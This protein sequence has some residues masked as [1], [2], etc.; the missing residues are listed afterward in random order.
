M[1]IGDM[2]ILQ[3]LNSGDYKP[4]ITYLNGTVAEIVDTCAKGE[5]IRAHWPGYEG[6]IYEA[7][8]PLYHIKTCEGMDALIC[9]D[10]IRPIDDPDQGTDQERDYEYDHWG[11]GMT[12]AHR[13]AAA[14][15]PPMTKADIDRAVEALMAM[16]RVHKNYMRAKMMGVALPPA[17]FLRKT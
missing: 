9:R 11:V 12:T 6:T 10:H 13:R 8:T 7:L 16:A 14:L 5:K 2:G 15:P 17:K 4:G 1:N 3:H